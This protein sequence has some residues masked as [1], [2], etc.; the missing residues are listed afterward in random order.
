MHPNS[1]LGRAVE[2]L[3]KR[4]TPAS[5][6]LI[7]TVLLIFGKCFK[8]LLVAEGSSAVGVVML[9]IIVFILPS[10]ILIRTKDKH[11]L[12]KLLL[13]PGKPETLLLS[14]LSAMVLI[15]GGLLLSILTAGIRQLPAPLRCTTP[16]KHL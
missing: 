13:K 10:A 15:S 3:Q 2:F 5:V 9:P 6:A 7:S 11:Y 16:L 1:F 8:P 4:H 14:L 12:S